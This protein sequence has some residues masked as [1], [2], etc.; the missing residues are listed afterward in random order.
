MDA[1]SCSKCGEDSTHFYV[2]GY[3]KPFS[4]CTSCACE[5]NEILGRLNHRKEYL[6][7]ETFNQLKN[8]VSTK[9]LKEG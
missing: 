5:F 7:E 3:D 1:V 2:S 8:W 4:L 9:F 6:N